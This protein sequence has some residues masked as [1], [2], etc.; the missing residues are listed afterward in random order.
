MSIVKT[1]AYLSTLIMGGIIVWAN[2]QSNFFKNT[3]KVASTAWGII[4]LV[5]LYI[6]FIFIGLWI[7]FR[8]KGISIII[9]FVGLFFL[10]NLT[11]ALHII[12]CIKEVNGNLEI[13]FIEKRN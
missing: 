12:Y 5:D 1:I 11:T 9:W 8:E 3:S 7:I 6:G 2:F 10:G 4:T 13:F